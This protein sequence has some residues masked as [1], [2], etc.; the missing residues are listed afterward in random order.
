MPTRLADGLGLES[1]LGGCCQLPYAP[2][3]QR[4]NEAG[5]AVPP[6]RRQG[7]DAS[8]GC[9]RTTVPRSGWNTRALGKR[10]NMSNLGK[11]KPMVPAVPHFLPVGMSSALTGK[12]LSKRV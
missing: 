7:S 12:A 1:G 10:L 6:C 9:A 5:N 4:Y 11:R 3:L 8:L 2:S